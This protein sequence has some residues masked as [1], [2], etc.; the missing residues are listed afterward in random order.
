MCVG[1]LCGEGVCLGV[2][3]FNK[4]NSIYLNTISKINIKKY[5]K[6]VL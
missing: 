1:G 4:I 3:V 6:T 2:C 5:L